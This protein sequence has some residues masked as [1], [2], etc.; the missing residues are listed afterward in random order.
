[1]ATFG[2]LDIKQ[3]ERYTREA[4]RKRLTRENAHLLGTNQDETSLTLEA[5]PP[6]VREK[7]EKR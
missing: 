7:V 2:W 5:S 4:E 3:A 1:M 6:P